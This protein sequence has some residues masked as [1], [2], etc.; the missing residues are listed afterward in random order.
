MAIYRALMEPGAP[1]DA[2]SVCRFF[3]NAENAFRK[4]T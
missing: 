2:N 4:V 1:L 3:P